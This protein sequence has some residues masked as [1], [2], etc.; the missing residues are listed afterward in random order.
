MWKQANEQK[1][2]ARRNPLGDEI[3]MKKAVKRFSGIA[4]VIVLSVLLLGCTKINQANFDKVQNDMTMSEVEAILG[5]PTESNSVGIGPL[6]GANVVWKGEKGT[7]TIQYLGGKVK[8][9]TF[10]ESK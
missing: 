3:E 6:S 7:I 10:S 8:M 5:K 1:I 2:E 9:K 4:S